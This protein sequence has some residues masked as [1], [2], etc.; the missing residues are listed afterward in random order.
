MPGGH[1][2]PYG[3]AMESREGTWLAVALT[4][5]LVAYGVLAIHSH[6]D[7]SVRSQ[8]LWVSSLLGSAATVLAGVALRPHHL[9]LGT[10]LLI[11]GALLAVIPTM[12]TFVLPPLELGVVVFALRDHQRA[13]QPSY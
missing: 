4:I 12:W 11:V 5:I 9:H 10:A 6:R 1:R 7:D 13:S 3:S 2:E 8:M